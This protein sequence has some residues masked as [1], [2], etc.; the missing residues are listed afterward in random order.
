M[1][2]QTW[3]HEDKATCITGH[4]PGLRDTSPIHRPHYRR[5]SINKRMLHRP[6]YRRCSIN[7][8]TLSPRPSGCIWRWS[9]WKVMKFRRGHGHQ[10]GVPTM[11][12]GPHGRDT[13][14]LALL[15]HGRTRPEGGPCKPGT[16]PAGTLISDFQPPELRNQCPVEA[17]CLW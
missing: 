12:L 9:L 4:Q 10:G 13:G 2:G 5:C 8:G 17:K 16:E 3:P 14:E 6:H 7:K 15:C 1:L 11:G